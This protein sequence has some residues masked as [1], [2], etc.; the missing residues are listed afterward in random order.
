METESLINLRHHVTSCVTFTQ[1]ES[2]EGLGGGEPC[3]PLMLQVNK[4]QV[5]VLGS[6]DLSGFSGAE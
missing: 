1:I 3:Y 2:W 5:R 6:A 4:V